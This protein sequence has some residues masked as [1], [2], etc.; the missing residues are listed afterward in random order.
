[1]VKT[2]WIIISDSIRLIQISMQMCC[3][4]RNW[5][6]SFLSDSA[7]GTYVS[8]Q[9]VINYFSSCE[10]IYRIFPICQCG[11]SGSSSGSI[12]L[13]QSTSCSFG[14]VKAIIQHYIPQ[15]WL[16]I[17]HM[18]SLR[19]VP[20][21]VHW[22]TTKNVLLFCWRSITTFNNF[23]NFFIPVVS[24]ETFYESLISLVIWISTWFHIR[25]CCTLLICSNAMLSPNPC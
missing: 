15:V 9:F 18:G 2:V 8:V 19:A 6:Y 21:Q 24:T 10:M 14:P 23:I 1:M 25:T 12:C 22:S 20:S 11:S 3:W 16:V 13:G 4:Q 5:N 17:D 7:F